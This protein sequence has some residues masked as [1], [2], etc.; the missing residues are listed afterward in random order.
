MPGAHLYNR[1]AAGAALLEA[2]ASLVLAV[3]GTGMRATTDSVQQGSSLLN[4]PMQAREPRPPAAGRTRRAAE[5]APPAPPAPLAPGVLPAG[6]RDPFGLLGGVDLRALADALAGAVNLSACASAARFAEDEPAAAPDD[7]EA[8]GDAGDSSESCARC[9][10]QMCRSA[11]GLSST[12]SGCGLIL[13]GGEA[14]LDDPPPGSATTARLRIVGPNSSQLQPD[15]YRSG[16]GS[17][18]ATQKKQIFE[19]YCAY[20]AL[21]VEAGGRAL[22]L[23]ACKLASDLYN[24][25]QLQCVKRSQNKKRIMAAC[26]YNACLKVGIAPARADIAAFMQL[27]GKGIASGTNFV[28]ALVA[29]GKMDAD[30]DIDVDPCRPEITTLFAHLGLEGEAFDG[31][32]AAVFDVVQVA[33]ANNIGTSSILR[34]K[35]AGATFSVLRRCND[36]RLVPKP[37]GLQEFCLA[38]IRKNTIERFLRQLDSYHSYFEGVYAQC[39]LDAGPPR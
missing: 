7:S 29:D 16:S 3:L 31:L 11:S 14:D 30:V 38:R 24:G 25:V 36:R 23:D 15:L 18:A 22:P 19:E 21:Y 35:V 32:R 13:E 2:Q 1:A 9:G 37:I 12:C 28:R 20:R 33:I 6:F 10:A 26:L 27:P 4:D 34:S 8:A 5:T 39:G 17:S